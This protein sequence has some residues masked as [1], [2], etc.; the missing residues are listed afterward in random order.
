M[1]LERAS[2]REL[3]KL[4]ANHILSHI[5]GQKAATIVDVEVE[6]DEVRSDRRTTRP[7]L[8]RLA[9]VAGLSHSYLFGKMRIYKETFFN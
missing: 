9:I 8:D 5:N 6:T 1:A 2:W 7:S 3:T 4:V